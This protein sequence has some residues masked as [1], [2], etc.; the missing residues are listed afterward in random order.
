[1]TTTSIRS[2]SVIAILTAMLVGFAPRTRGAEEPARLIVHC[3]RPCRGVEA[4]VLLVGGE[5]TYAYENVDAIAVSV[6]QDRVSELS[7]IEGVLAVSKD[8][9]VDRP[10]PIAPVEAAALDEPQALSPDALQQFLQDLPENYNYNNTL[11]RAS[12]VQ[13]GGALGQDVVVAVIDT[14]V[15]ILAPAL[16]PAGTGT[17]IGGENLVPTAT[18]PVRSATSRLNDWHGTTV[19]SMIAAHVAFIFADTSTLVRSLRVHSPSSVIPCTGPPSCPLGNSLVP[20]IGTA[21][22]ARV[23]ALKVFPSQGGRAPESRIIAAIDRAITL[24]RNFN[25]GLPTTPVSGTGS[26][27]DPFVYNS[28]NI[29]VVNMSLGGATLFAGHELEEELTEALRDVGI[30]VTVAAGNAGFGAITVESPGSGFG[31]IRVAAANTPVHERVLRDNQLGLGAGLLYRPSDEIQTAYFSS[32]GPI[33]D[34]RTGPQIIANGFASYTN[35]FAAVSSAGALV[36]CGSPTAVAGSCLSRILFVSGTSFSTPTVAGA[37]A[38]L[39]GWIP[40]AGPGAVRRALLQ[41]ANRSILGDGST[42]F[43]QGAGFLDV[44][45]ALHRLAAIVDDDDCEDDGNASCR[46]RR[47]RREDGPDEVGAGGASVI[48]NVR[49][50]GLSIVQFRNGTYSAHINDL[51]PGEV[52]QFFVPVNNRTD[53]LT[54]RFTEITPEGPENTLFGDDLLVMG[55]DAPTSV[56]V[57]RIG[58]G[59]VFVATDTTFT[60]DNPQTGLFR[61]AVQGDWTNANVISAHVAIERTVTPLGEPTATDRIEQDDLVPV[62]VDIPAGASQAVFELF[63]QQ[64]WGRYPTNDLDMILFRPDGSLYLVGGAPPGA[65]LDSPERVVIANPPAGRWIVVVD[66]FTVWDTNRGP[67]SGT[68]RFVLRVSADGTPIVD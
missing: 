19:T 37:A 14:G 48:Q 18:D 51:K 24:R 65:T 41:S 40:S 59:G 2:L 32:R 57:H 28:L 45:E 30:V 53:R 42:R 38:L 67:R 55:I 60:I 23:Y 66:G 22:L 39:R 8:V 26:E 25:N 10:V 61:L 54:I 43:D 33:A 64:N 31:T 50:A 52:K 63:W 34:G 36:S 49:E 44:H 16:G 1:M 46:N 4:A 17:V 15:Q 3:E 29:Q 5:I 9:S 6:P 47:E 7:A 20:M 58:T 27:D 21:P 12:E 56:A 62:P 13:A 11:T 68:D 35:A